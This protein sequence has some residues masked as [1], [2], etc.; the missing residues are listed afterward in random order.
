MLDGNA[1]A[2]PETG[3]REVLATGIAALAFGS[4]P[5]LFFFQVVL[6]ALSK[7][8]NADFNAFF[9]ISLHFFQILS[10]VV[11]KFKYIYSPANQLCMLGYIFR[12][13]QLCQEGRGLVLTA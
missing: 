10:M 6:Q 4:G 13:Y 12:S 9:D 2:G 7:G 3:R 8:P 1:N 5:S 11:V